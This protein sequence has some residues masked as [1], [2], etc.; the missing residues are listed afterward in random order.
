MAKWKAAG[1]GG[2][3]GALLLGV[4]QAEPVLTDLAGRTVELDGPAERIVTLPVPMAATVIALDQ[5][6]DRLVGIHPESK[7]AIDDE[8]LGVIF[9]DLKDISSAILAGGA[10]RGQEP[11][12]EA[13]QALEP[14]LVIQWGAGSD[15]HRASE[16]QNVAP[17]EK[18]GLDMVLIVRGPNDDYM[19][20]ALDLI[21]GAIGQSERAQML[22]DWRDQVSSEIEAGLEGVPEG[23]RPKAAYFFYSADELWTEGGDTFGGWQLEHV[24]AQNAA[25]EIESWGEVGA[26]QVM[27]WN[28]DVI[29][30]STFEPDAH[31]DQIYEHEILGETTAAK[32]NRIYQIPVGGYRWDPASPESPLAWMWYAEVLHPEVFDF[33]LRAEIKEWY[34]KLWGHTPTEEQIDQILQIDMNGG[35]A[36]YEQF[37]TQ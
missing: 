9:P 15:L 6:S 12:V 14:D 18:A 5:S 20:E 31:V 33:D 7:L 22:I 32:T 25:E 2:G 19:R 23:D 11:D 3:L 35:S 27:E 30:I 29:F 17:L 37:A 26:E 36:G 10:T 13:I 21:G 28:P 1:V 34:P 16:D 24:G 4:A 8:I